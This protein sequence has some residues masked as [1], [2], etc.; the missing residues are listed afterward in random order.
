MR[1]FLKLFSYVSLEIS[2][3]TDCICFF[4]QAGKQ[5]N[6]LIIKQIQSNFLNA[7]VLYACMNKIV[8]IVFW[9]QFNGYTG[10][11][12]IIASIGVKISTIL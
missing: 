6:K 9:Q 1:C 12:G 2:S 3:K 4:E 7:V 8:N 11:A 10:V 5:N